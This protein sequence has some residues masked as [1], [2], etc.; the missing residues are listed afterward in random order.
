MDILAVL[1]TSGDWEDFR[2]KLRPL[3]KGEKGKCF[4]ALTKYFLCLHPTY[5][6]KL[7]H[8][9]LLREVPAR[10]RRRVKLPD[11]D[12]G[13]DLVAQ[14]RDGD[15]W[16]IQCKFKEDEERP[17]GRKELST[18]TDLA[19]N[20]CEGISLGLVCTTAER[21][22]RKLEGYENL[23]FCTGEV[24]RGL[25]HEFFSR[26]RA[27]LGRRP[28]APIP[29]SPRAH[30]KRA[31]QSAFRHFG[32]Q[33]NARGKL[34]MPCGTGKS[35]T[36]YWIARK[37]GAKSVLV[38]VPSLALIRQTLETWSRQSIAD[39]SPIE[40][41][42]VCS[43][44]SV[45]DFGERRAAVLSQDLGIRIHTSPVDIARWLRERRR[46]MTVVFSTYQSG[47]A[48][49]EG[50]RKAKAAFELGVFD[51]AHKTVGQKGGLFSHLLFDDNVQID[52]RILMTATERHYRGRAED[53]V[54]MDDPDLYGDTFE[55]LSFKEALQHRPP[56]LCDYRIVTVAVSRSEVEE[57]VRRNLLVRPDRG[58]WGC[59]QRYGRSRVLRIPAGHDSGCLGSL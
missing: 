1:R 43:D 20:L 27:L 40:W 18:F 23:A 16:A 45:G 19:F 41:M 48:L 8:V 46:G 51:E 42:C 13:I 17:L 26:L 7:E 12:E 38:A 57:L 53:I 30:Q 55:L 47:P 52:R 6:T 49:A 59:S 31:V 10:V 39:G 56:I 14:T 22:S 25:D 36:A 44:E 15:I 21:Y 28:Q 24:W 33:G 9:W 35:L 29:L 11:Q 34:I 32:R 58:K 50:A 5:A 54:S 3:S 4:E 2:A 37:L